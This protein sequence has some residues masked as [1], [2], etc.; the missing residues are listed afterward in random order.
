MLVLLFQGSTAFTE[1]ITVR[2]YPAYRAYQQLESWRPQSFCTS[3]LTESPSSPSSGG[4][5]QDEQQPEEQPL[6]LK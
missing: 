4:A 6:V 3:T 1:Y 5:T 2:K